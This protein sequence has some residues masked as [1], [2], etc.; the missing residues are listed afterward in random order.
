MEDKIIKSVAPL[1]Y[2]LMMGAI[3]G[4]VY[5]VIAIII[6]LFWL[7]ALSATLNAMPIPGVSG[8]IAGLGVLMVILMPIGGFIAGFLFGLV[9]AALYNFLAPRIGGVKVRFEE[10]KQAP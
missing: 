8:L 4:I 3:T 9:F 5:L 6:A 10:T 1:P 7:P 2:A